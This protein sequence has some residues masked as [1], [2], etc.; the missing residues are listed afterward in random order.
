LGYPPDRWFRW[1]HY[2]AGGDDPRLYMS[3]GIGPKARQ[4]SGLIYYSE[5]ILKDEKR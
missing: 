5:I 2:G 3:E 4:G 1:Y